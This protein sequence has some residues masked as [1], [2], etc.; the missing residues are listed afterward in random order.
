LSFTILCLQ[1][2]LI[3]AAGLG[4]I[5]PTWLR[6]A[7]MHADPKSAI[8]QPSDQCLFCPFGICVHKS[9]SSNVGEMDPRAQ[10][11]TS[12]NTK[13]VPETTQSV[14]CKKW[15]KLLFPRYDGKDKLTQKLQSNLS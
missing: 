15:S 7:F 8:R 11:N 1:R 3:I 13:D 10:N 6:E 14:S 9:C 2:P 12:F 4:L 5:S